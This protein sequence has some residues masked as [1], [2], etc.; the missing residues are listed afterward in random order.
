MLPDVTRRI[1]SAY[2]HQ[3][4][5]PQMA[6]IVAAGPGAGRVVVVVWL[7][8]DDELRPGAAAG[9]VARGR[10]GAAAAA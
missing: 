8:V 2:S 7:R 6:Q 9:R 10:P 1:G 4:V 5:L 3:D